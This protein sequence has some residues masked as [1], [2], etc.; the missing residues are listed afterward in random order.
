MALVGAESVA[1][2]EDVREGAEAEVAAKRTPA[3]REK[4]MIGVRVGTSNNH[5]AE[6]Y[7]KC[8]L[9]GAVSLPWAWRS[10][11][12]WG[13]SL[14]VDFTAA[15]LNGGPDWAFLGSVVPSFFLLKEQW[16]LALDGG[17]GPALL[18]RYRFGET[19]NLGG[20]FQFYSHAGLT[21]LVRRNLTVGYQWQH[22]S[23]AGIYSPNPGIN[24]HS[25]QLAY[26]FW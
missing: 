21:Y 23:N 3:A 2:E 24:F 6:I 11:S 17:I 5:N 19:D 20:H 9:L 25:L 26:L 8:E 15:V 7:Y 18:S 4:A 16:R 1:A 12:G 22:L 14:R 13:F 10:K